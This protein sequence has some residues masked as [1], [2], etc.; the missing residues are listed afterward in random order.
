MFVRT[1]HK[2]SSHARCTASGSSCAACDDDSPPKPL[3]HIEHLT[4][5]TRSVRTHLTSDFLQLM[6]SQPETFIWEFFRGE[7]VWRVDNYR[8][9]LQFILKQVSLSVFIFLNCKSCV[10]MHSMWPIERDQCTLGMIVP[11]Y[12]CH[13]ALDC[14]IC[15]FAS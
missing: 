2:Q 15:V 3:P 4:E 5:K 7:G 11:S 13:G 8:S 1:G 6:W 9:C 10:Q 14:Y 12:T